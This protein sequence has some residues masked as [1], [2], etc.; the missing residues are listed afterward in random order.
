[1]RILGGRLQPL[2]AAVD[3]ALSEHTLHA[4]ITGVPSLLRHPVWPATDPDQ[5]NGQGVVLVP[6]FGVGE[7]SL[8]LTASWLRARGYKPIGARIGFNVGCTTTLVDRIVQRMTEHADATGGPIVL[9][10]Q[11][12]GG[13]LARLATVRRPELVRGLVMLGSPVLDPL[14]ANPSVVKLA[15]SLA[16]LSTYGVPGLL[17][18]DCFEGDCYRES[19]EALTIPLPSSIPA[20]AVYSRLDR[21]APWK[22]CRD[23]Y[24]RCVEVRS[25]HTGMAFDPEVYTALE[26]RLRRWARNHDT[27]KAVVPEL[28]RQRVS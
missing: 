6:G 21:I 22:L 16:R 1:M 18:Q 4:I 17:D 24:A 10:G 2:M 3:T 11:S 12:R 26:P 5:G 20:V 7:Y 27:A 15:R 9:I 25:S 28:P 23:P 19:A 13:W 8:A 14:G